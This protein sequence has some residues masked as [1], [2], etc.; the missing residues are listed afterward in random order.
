MS[1]PRVLPSRKNRGNFKPVVYNGQAAAKSIQ[2]LKEGE[3]AMAP[4]K[5]AA[6]V[7]DAAKAAKAA[8]AATAAKA[9]KRKKAAAPAAVEAPEVAEPP[10]SAKSTARAERKKK[11][12]AAKAAK[13]AKAAEATKAAVAAAA[14]A[15]AA[16]AAKARANGGSEEEDEYEES[17]D[18]GD[19]D[20]VDDDDGDGEDD[21]DTDST[22]D[23][24]AVMSDRTKGDADAS[25]SDSAGAVAAAGQRRKLDAVL[26]RYKPSTGDTPQKRRRVQQLNFQEAYGGAVSTAAEEVLTMC[27]ASLRQEKRGPVITAKI[28][29]REE[30]ALDWVL[31]TQERRFRKEEI[32]DLDSQVHLEATLAKLAGKYNPPANTTL[33]LF[34]PCAHSFLKETLT[35]DT[36]VLNS[37][38]RV[39]R[40]KT[41]KGG[42]FG[43]RFMAV[44]HAA[45]VHALLLDKYVY[46]R[47]KGHTAP[48]KVPPIEI[49]L[50]AR[51]LKSFFLRHDVP[52][53]EGGSA[54]EDL[55]VADMYY[56]TSAIAT[57]ESIARDK[58]AS[59]L[60]DVSFAKNWSIKQS[61]LKRVTNT[62]T[63]G[64]K[65]SAAGTKKS[66]GQAAAETGKAPHQKK[67]KNQAKAASPGSSKGSREGP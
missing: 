27:T 29:E 16:A 21:G 10:K 51:N 67:K 15:V 6:K 20:D 57:D 9:A 44:V 26:G 30:S 1:E 37:L 14:A 24:D 64:S 63:D 2:R 28:E 39:L 60:A 55:M 22:S 53:T 40:K 56:E 5:K 8:K 43:G 33:Q 23:S 25:D 11:V 58:A 13:A 38:R 36:T 34:T 66:A 47:V 32:E 49:E 17:G 7:N 48:T 46:S 52:S 42:L 59:H 62:D 50:V 12:R 3:A 65:L 45:E 54:S 18:D 41:K 31:R 4:P 19:D 35:T 61:M